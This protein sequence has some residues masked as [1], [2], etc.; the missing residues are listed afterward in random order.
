[1]GY[2]I[3][4]HQELTAK[5]PKLLPRSVKEEGFEEHVLSKE[6]RLA[7]DTSLC[8][9]RAPAAS[10]VPSRISLSIQWRAP[11]TAVC[12]RLLLEKL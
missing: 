6:M 7:H 8:S 1:M 9:Q 3:A 12:C 5:Y 4:M 11:E 2:A 10:P